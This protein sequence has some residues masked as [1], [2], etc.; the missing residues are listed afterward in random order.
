MWDKEADVV[1]VGNGGA[2]A[3]AAIT[4][5]DAGARVIVLEKLKQGGGATRT[6]GGSIREYL[7]LEKAITYFHAI[8]W[9]TTSKEVYEAFVHEG[10]RVPQWVR[11]MGGMLEKR[12]TSGFPPSPSVV[13]PHVAGADGIGGRWRV[14]GSSKSFGANLWAILSRNIEERAVEVLF[15]TAASELITTGGR[16]IIGVLANG[17][18]GQ[19]R[20]RAARAVILACGGFEFSPEMQLNFLGI[21]FLALGSPGNTGDGIRMAQE[22][23][24]ALWHMNGLSC[25]I[26]YKVPDFDYPFNHRI[27]TGEY[28]YVDQNGRRFVNE[29]G[30]DVHAMA[31]AFCHLDHKTLK[32]PRIPSYVIFDEVARQKGPI[33]SET[34][35]MPNY[36]DWSKDNTEEIRRGWIKTAGTIREL[37]AQIGLRPEV[38]QE[39]VSRYNICCAGGYDPEFGRYQETLSAIVTPPFYAITVQPCLINTQGG[40]KRNERAQVLDVHQKPIKRLYSAGELGSI[41]GILYPGAGNVTECLTF[42]RIA[43][44]NAA[45]ELPWSDQGL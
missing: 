13:F 36:Y 11:D 7:D 23:G 33:A 14:N 31:F 32:Y 26:G 19:V 37:A 24:A 4:A 5:H 35:W 39:T 9:E 44:R 12:E 28:I 30:T 41:W 21:K 29:A 43:G 8:S 3:A 34:G 45:A 16:E 20:V 10:S 15:E 38:L 42:G 27:R 40:P 17:P 6:S 25:S 22:V 2:G 18:Q 1:I